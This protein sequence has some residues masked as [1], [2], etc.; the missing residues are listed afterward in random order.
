MGQCGHVVGLA[1]ALWRLAEPDAFQRAFHKNPHGKHQ[2]T[3]EDLQAYLASLPVSKNVQAAKKE[4]SL[5]ASSGDAF[6][7][8]AHALKSENVASS[9]LVRQQNPEATKQTG[10]KRAIRNAE[11]KKRQSKKS[12]HV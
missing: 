4:A 12:K 7:V 1:L 2:T 9:E 6:A 11:K 10:V 5:L 3:I 8:I